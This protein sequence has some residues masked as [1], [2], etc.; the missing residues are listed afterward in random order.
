MQRLEPVQP[1][2]HH[3][4]PAQG[5]AGTAGAKRPGAGGRVAGAEPRRSTQHHTRSQDQARQFQTH[6]PQP[7]TS[8][9]DVPRNRAWKAL[10]RPQPLAARG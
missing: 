5:G 4:S 9:S 6:Q 2:A 3:L 1:P 10:Q 7:N 8:E